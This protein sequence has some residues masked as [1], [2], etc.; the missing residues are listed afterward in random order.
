MTKKRFKK[1]RRTKSTKEKDKNN[2]T[3]ISIQWKIEEN[4]VIA[5]I[6]LMSDIVLRT[7][8]IY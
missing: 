5:F 8:Q 4:L 6:Y 7:L 2:K 3:E 1:N